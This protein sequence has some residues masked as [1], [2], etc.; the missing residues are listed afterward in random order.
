MKLKK[1]F[2]SKKILF[3]GQAL[4]VILAE[5]Q[6][7]ALQ[8]AEMVNVQYQGVRK[9]VLQLTQVVDNHMD[10]RIAE[11]MRI[12][13]T[14]KKDNVKHQITGRYMVEDQ[15]HY[16]METQCCVCVPSDE[17]LNVYSATQNVTTTLWAVAG[18]L[19]VK[20]N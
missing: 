2:A 3:Y 17:G 5:S 12:D 13:A 20:E 18:A 15:Y 10:D 14:D 9:P 1:I 6:V 4:G 11:I 16:T 8:A 7:V 19:N